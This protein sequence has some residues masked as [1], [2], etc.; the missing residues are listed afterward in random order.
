MKNNMEQTIDK[1]CKQVIVLHRLGCYLTLQQV[2]DAIKQEL[3]DV[4]V[5]EDYIRQEVKRRLKF[6]LKVA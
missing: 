1:V 4:D 5:D 6:K 3:N 2:V